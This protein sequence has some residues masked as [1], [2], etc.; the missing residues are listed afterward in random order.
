MYNYIC[1]TPEVL[2]QILGDRKAIS[3][4]FTDYYKDRE[5]DQV[6]ILGSGTSYHAALAA[7]QYLEEI[8]QIKVIPMYP[9][10]FE[11]SEKVFNRNTL[12]IGIS[13]GGQSLSTVA[14]LDM[15]RK[16][17][18]MTA[19][20]SENPTAL[21]FDHADT[22][23][24]IMV[25]NEKCGAKTKG[26]AGSILT[27]E[28][29]L[30][31]LAIAKGIFT[32]ESAETYYTRM[33]RV[34]GNL[35]NVTA[36]ATAWYDRIREDFLPAKRIIVIGYD[37]VYAAALE[38]ALKILETVRQGV[39]GY[40]IEEFFH[41]IYNS[42]SESSYIFYIAP[43]SDYKP[44]TQRLIEVLR[45]W[46]PHNYLIASPEGISETDDKYLLCDFTEDPLFSVWEYIIPL[47]VVACLAPQ[48]L[49]INPDIPKDPEF[50]AKVG[51]KV[52]DG[53]R[54]HYVIPTV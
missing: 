1:E 30:T 47:Q 53:V 46:T 25:G 12:V 3:R 11:R 6:Y 23:T 22:K 9:T 51:S 8:L 7:K 27:L 31:E 36:A 35:G 19:A 13:Q 54:D 17:G 26:Y 2:L 43:E 15:A 52:L 42:V 16:E 50:H 5:I 38:G 14:G 32:E 21:I 18:L 40:D 49:N 41:G 24:R 10:Q 33:K 44:R 37:N 20:V 39:T 48:D 29:M 45:K 28:L 34:I 4:E